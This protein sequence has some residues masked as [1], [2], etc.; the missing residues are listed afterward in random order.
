MAKVLIIG[1]GGVG[2]VMVHKC[3]QVAEVFDEIKSAA[4]DFG[5]VYLLGT[6]FAQQ[7]AGIQAQ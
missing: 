1:A 5:A 7:R 3:A 2:N 4:I 6:R